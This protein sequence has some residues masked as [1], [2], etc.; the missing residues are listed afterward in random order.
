MREQSISIARTARDLS[1][2]ENVLR[3]WGRL[4]EAGQFTR[5]RARVAV[6]KREINK[7]KAE[8][9]VLKNAAYFARQS[10]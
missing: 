5:F 9:D 4:Y 7:L 6:L 2:H 10:K 8:R 1:L 3:E